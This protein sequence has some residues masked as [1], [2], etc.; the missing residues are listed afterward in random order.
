MLSLAEQNDLIHEKLVGFRTEL[1]SEKRA[2]WSGKLKPSDTEYFI[3]IDYEL[4]PHFALALPTLDYFPRVYVLSPRLERR[5]FAQLGPLPHVWWKPD[6]QGEPCLCLF[7]AT[8]YD[9]TYSSPLTET[10]IPDASEW[11]FFY[12]LWLVTNKWFG[13]GDPHNPNSEEANDNVI[14]AFR[15]DTLSRASKIALAA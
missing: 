9:W 13:G 15:R 6:F 14:K 10:T 1:I 3:R 5:P 8:N 4:P 12:E 11:L 2:V 7:K